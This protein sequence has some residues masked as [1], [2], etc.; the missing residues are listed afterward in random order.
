RPEDKKRKA[1]QST[2]R[3]DRH[4]ILACRGRLR[5]KHQI[6]A[7]VSGE[8]QLHPRQSGGFGP[9]PLSGGLAPFDGFGICWAPARWSRSH[10]LGDGLK[11]VSRLDVEEK[12]QQTRGS[13]ACRT[14][15]TAGPNGCESRPDRL[16]HP[17][18]R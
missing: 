16:W 18:S 3:S 17:G 12:T 7:R 13:T 9:C 2:A 11:V 10:D 1:H 15:P 5:P 14:K 4:A 6:V 8:D